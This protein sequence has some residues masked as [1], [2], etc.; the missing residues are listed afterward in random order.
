MAFARNDGGTWRPCRPH[1]MAGGVWRSPTAAFRH[2]GTTWRQ[3]Y[4][5][6]GSGSQTI[7]LS[8]AGAPFYVI[9]N[10]TW[11]GVIVETSWNSSNGLL[12]LAF[13]ANVSQ[14]FLAHVNV[15]KSPEI[16]NYYSHNWS[17]VAFDGTYS[18]YIIDTDGNVVYTSGN[19]AFTLGG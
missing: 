7:A 3:F 6:D 16:T 2:D 4:T 5:T 9:P 10:F 14:F 13:A 17:F 1:V 12:T 18:T 19:I 8:G 11:K 15:N